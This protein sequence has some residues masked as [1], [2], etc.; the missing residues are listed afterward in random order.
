MLLGRRPIFIAL[1]TALVSACAGPQLPQLGPVAGNAPSA[2]VLA[3]QSSDPIDV[4]GRNG[5]PSE[6]T[7]GAKNRPITP[8]T[9][10]AEQQE[11][12]I[13]LRRDMIVLYRDESGFEGERMV[14]SSFTLPTPARRA[15][16]NPQRLEI[17]TAA[18]MRWVDR[19]EVVLNAPGR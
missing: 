7:D 13:G 4:S 5:T 17:L 18:G 2:P 6:L 15:S 1:T 19:A 11:A 3:T 12:I 9:N 10:A 14:A 16:N 8:R